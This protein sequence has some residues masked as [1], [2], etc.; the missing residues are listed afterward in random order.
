MMNRIVYSGI[1][2]LIAI[3]VFIVLIVGATHISWLWWA[4]IGQI[5]VSYGVFDWHM[6]IIHTFKARQAA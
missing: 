5:A 6:G 2:L 4:V 1:I 3:A